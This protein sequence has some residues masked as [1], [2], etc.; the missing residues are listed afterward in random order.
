MY[1]VGLGN[2]RILTAYAQK[3]TWTP[4]HLG[5]E[6]HDYYKIVSKSKSRP[7]S[8]LQILIVF[9][10]RMNFLFIIDVKIMVFFKWSYTSPPAG[11]PLY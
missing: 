9:G 8:F 6:T 10:A 3:F 11:P 5:H 4:L 1:L 2:T 7:Y